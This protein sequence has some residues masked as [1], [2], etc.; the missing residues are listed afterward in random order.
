RAA[1]SV[2]D[3]LRQP[4][5]TGLRR[6]DTA[7][8]RRARTRDRLSRHEDR[9]RHG[10]APRM[11]PALLLARALRDPATTAGLSASE[12]TAL[13]AVA[14]AEQLIGTLATRLDGLPVSSDAARIIRDAIASARSEE[15]RVGEE[16]S[17]GGRS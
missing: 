16:W 2:V 3:Q 14:R 5:R 7:G 10:G 6:A 15:R 8:P 12:W 11:R 1:D 9:A 13:F 17:S 4:S